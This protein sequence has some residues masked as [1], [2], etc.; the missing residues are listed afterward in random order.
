MLSQVQLVELFAANAKGC[1]ATAGEIV[2][3]YRCRNAVTGTAGRISCS[4]C[5]ML[6]QVQLVEVFALMQNCC[7]MCGW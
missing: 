6:S 7:P 4:R 3:R 1:Q 5:K 2:D